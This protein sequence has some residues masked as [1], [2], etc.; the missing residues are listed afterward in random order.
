MKPVAVRHA[1]LCPVQELKP[2]P[3]NVRTH[4]R[5]QKRLLAKLIRTIGWTSPIV[6]DGDMMVLAGHLRLDAAKELK[7]TDVPVVVI[8]DLSIAERRAFMLADNQIAT[9]AGWDRSLLLAELGDLAPQLEQFGLDLPDLGF[10]IGEINLLHADH[11]QKRGDPSDELPPEGLPLTSKPGS[12]WCLGKLKHEI[13]CGDARSKPD[14]ELLLNGG[15]AAMAFIDPPY[16]V[17]IGDVVGRGKTHHAEFAMASGEMSLAEFRSFIASAF[18]PLIKAIKNG[19]L[20]YCCIDWRS[21][22]LVMAVAREMFGTILNVVVWNKTNAGQGSFYRSQHELI[23]VLKVGDGP[24]CNGVELGKYGRNRSN[25]WTYAGANTFRKGRQEELSVHPTVKPVSLVADAMKDCTLPGDTV[26][27]TFLGSGTT[28]LAA[29][30]IGRRCLGIEL[31]PKYVDLAIR[32]WQAFTKLDAYCAVTGRAFD[33][34]AAEPS[35]KT[36]PRI[37]GLEPPHAPSTGS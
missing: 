4:N 6:V 29:E 36:D 15:G 11:G 32:R 23:L 20:V 31:E 34:I 12:R 13:L 3:R 9:L 33:D 7:L 28:L 18:N 1:R 14:L 37:T 22:D 26:I 27:D 5:H 35:R 25:V 2:N 21:V 24:H 10:P 17:V 16:N 30:K 8:D 19:G